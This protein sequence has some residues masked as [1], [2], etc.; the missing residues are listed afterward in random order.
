MLLPIEMRDEAKVVLESVPLDGHI[1]NVLMQR[2]NEARP[3]SHGNYIPALEAAERLLN[4]FSHGG[5]ALNLLFLS[6][7]RPSDARHASPLIPPAT[8]ATPATPPQ[9][10]V[11]SPVG[12]LATPALPRC[13]RT[14]RKRVRPALTPAIRAQLCSPQAKSSGSNH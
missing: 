10:P 3:S 4:K 8:P 11:L 12:F 9:S 1:F 13:A 6:D 5:C 2:R 7:G 14:V